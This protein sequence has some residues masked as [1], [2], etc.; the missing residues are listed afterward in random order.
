MARTLRCCAPHNIAPSNRRPAGRCHSLISLLHREIY[1]VQQE[2]NRPDRVDQHGNSRVLTMKW[3]LIRV[4]AV[5][6]RPALAVPLPQRGESRRDPAMTMDETV[7]SGHQT[8]W[9][10]MR[11]SQPEC[12][13]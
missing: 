4:A 5:W 3:S 13:F 7:A 9:Q 6:R 12:V 8:F 2:K 1:Q 11:R 10:R